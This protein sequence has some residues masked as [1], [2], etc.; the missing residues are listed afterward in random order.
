MQLKWRRVIVLVLTLITGGIG[1]Y[2]TGFTA[3][4]PQADASFRALMLYDAAL[5]TDG[6]LRLSRNIREGRQECIAEAVESSLDFAI[7][8]LAEF[9][10]PE[11]G[12][13]STQA[14]E[15]LKSARDYRAAFQHNPRS[16]LLA[17]ELSAAL[18]MQINESIR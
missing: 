16:K 11:F 17:Q 12:D 10:T 18:S 8:R 13:L 1:G 15:S 7:V 14:A 9:Y 6:A 2:F 3:A 4:G 5:K